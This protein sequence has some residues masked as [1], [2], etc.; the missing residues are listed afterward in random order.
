MSQAFSIIAARLRENTGVNIELYRLY[1]AVARGSI[2]IRG[3]TLDLTPLKD[4]T[5][6]KLASAIASEVERLWADDWDID[7]MVLTGGGGGILAPYLKP[8]LEGE[9][10]AID[11]ASDT[12][13][14]NVR[15]LLEV[16]RQHLGTRG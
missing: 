14:N 11:A 9:L 4:E 13:L 2:K 8:L 5:F 15:G 1:E 10:M 6:G 16:R 3:K 12:R 7:R